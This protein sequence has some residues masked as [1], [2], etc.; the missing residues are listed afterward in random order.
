MPS[1]ILQAQS[2]KSSCI[3]VGD[4]SYQLKANV[5]M[6]LFH[7]AGGSFRQVLAGWKLGPQGGELLFQSAVSVDVD[8]VS[9]LV[10][11]VVVVERNAV[12]AMM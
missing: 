5:E 11:V 3:G 6:T 4:R 7:W 8:E 10:V 1:G 9:D 12:W 2:G